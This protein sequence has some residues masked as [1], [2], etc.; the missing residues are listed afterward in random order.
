M[1]RKIRDLFRRGESPSVGDRYEQLGRRPLAPEADASEE[2][3][4]ALYRP[5]QPMT[6]DA[7][8]DDTYA[9]LDGRLP[10]DEYF[11]RGRERARQQVEADMRAKGLR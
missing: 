11:A 9:Y 4:E 8:D 2:A 1:W 6:Q 3:T 7:I 10:A 5:G